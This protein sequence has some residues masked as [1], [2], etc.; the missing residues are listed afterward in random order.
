MNRGDQ[1][2]EEDHFHFTFSFFPIAISF[3][4]AIGK[5]NEK[6]MKMI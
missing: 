1:E 6:E 4:L 2:L 3:F 5:E